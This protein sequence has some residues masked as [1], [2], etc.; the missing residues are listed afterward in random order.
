MNDKKKSFRQII[1]ATSIFGGVQVFQIIISIARSKIIAV[2]LGPAGMGIAGLLSSTLGIIASVT[3]LGL[4]ISAVKDVAEAHASGDEKRVS[5]VISVFRRLVWLTGLFGAVFTMLASRW[6]SQLTFGNQNYTLA[7]VWISITLLLNQLSSGRGVLLQGMRQLQ[8]QAKASMYGAL[9]GLLVSTPIYY[10]FRIDGI[11]PSI[12]IS[13][14]IGLGLEWFYSSKLKVKG[15]GVDARTLY[16]EGKEMVRMGVVLSMSGFIGSIGAYI[17][18]VFI[19][20]NG[21]VAEVGLYNAGF[22]IVNTYVG[23]VFAAMGTD[24]YPRLS[25]ISGDNARARELINQQAEVSVII[26]SPILAVFITCIEFVVVLMYSGK[27]IPIS[28][29][30]QWAAIGMYFKAVS[31]AIAYI[32]LAKGESVLFFWSELVASIYSLLFGMLGYKIAGLEGIGISFV[33]GYFCYLLQV[34]I[35]SKYKY[36]FSF[37]VEFYRVFLIELSVGVA[38]FLIVRFSPSPFSYILS[39]PVMLFAFIYSFLQMDKRV[40]VRGFIAKKFK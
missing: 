36:R 35:I 29:M 40:D 22:S 39:A 13:S 28:G 9:I 3:N 30:I 34:L 16:S 19:S 14:V 27:F 2:L 24:Y 25:E 33:V 31:W 32:L 12:I 17:I 7:F 37:D 26:L 38:C 10:F 21:G 4:G 15:V 5:L 20:N 8:Y 18:R 11:V 1:K 6:L 23:M